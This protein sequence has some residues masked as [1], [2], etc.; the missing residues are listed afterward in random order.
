MYVGA[1]GGLFVREDEAP[2]GKIAQPGGVTEDLDAGLT[3][4]DQDIAAL[5]LDDRSPGRG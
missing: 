5:R 4:P 1:V 2:A 3:V